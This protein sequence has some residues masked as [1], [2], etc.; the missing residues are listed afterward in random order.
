MILKT[1]PGYIQQSPWLTISN[2][3]LDLMARFMSGLGLTPSGRS[4]LAVQMQNGRKPWE[5]DLASA[6]L[7]R[8]TGMGR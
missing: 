8:G 6:Y 7:D 5:V 4:R 3:Q 2:Q 1:S